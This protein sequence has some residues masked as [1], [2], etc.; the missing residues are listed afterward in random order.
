MQDA[1]QEGQ[2]LEALAKH[3]NSKGSARPVSEGGLDNSHFHNMQNVDGTR[4]T[5]KWKT[6]FHKSQ[7]TQ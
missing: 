5:G 4:P 1:F 7:L 2:V 3:H 6:E